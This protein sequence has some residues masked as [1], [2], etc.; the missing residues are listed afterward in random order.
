MWAFVTAR[1]R[2]FSLFAGTLVLAMPSLATLFDVGPMGYHVG[3]ELFVR[4][5][6]LFLAM[7]SLAGVFAVAGYL[8]W[9]R[10]IHPSQ[11]ATARR[12]ASSTSITGRRLRTHP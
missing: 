4:V 9:V 2:H 11:I 5:I 1:M 8:Y 10:V 6:S 12:I 7:T 3:S